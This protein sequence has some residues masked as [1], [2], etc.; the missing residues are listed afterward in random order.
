M[1]PDGVAVRTGLSLG[2]AERP[3][4][5]QSECQTRVIARDLT[6]SALERSPCLLVLLGGDLTS[7]QPPAEDV[8]W[9]LGR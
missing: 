1:E 2:L 7:G 9:L 3:D 8:H 5:R 4:V 6:S